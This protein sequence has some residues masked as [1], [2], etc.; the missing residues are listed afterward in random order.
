MSCHTWFSYK[1]D[2]LLQQVK[3]DALYICQSQIDWNQKYIDDPTLDRNWLENQ[4]SNT[5]FEYSIYY[6]TKCK[7]FIEKGFI[8]TKKSLSRFY[9]YFIEEN[10]TRF[11]EVGYEYCKR[12]DSIYVESDDMP[13][14]IFRIGGYPVDE[15]LSYDET[16]AF[17]QLKKVELSDLQKNELKE[18]WNQYPDGRII[19]G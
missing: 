5:M 19:F 11:L 14:D 13:H 17:C 10:N 12:N 2:I 1:K 7:R 18:F 8:K 3:E 16:I 9:D 4:E 6:F 15:L